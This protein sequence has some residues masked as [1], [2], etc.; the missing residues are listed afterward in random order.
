MEKN[1][2]R[3]DGTIKRRERRTNER[4]GLPVSS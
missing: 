2:N 4:G 3:R 1:S